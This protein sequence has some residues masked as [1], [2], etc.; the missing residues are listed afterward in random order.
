MA[1]GLVLLSFLLLAWAYS[2]VM[3]PFENLDEIEHFSAIRF[4]AET[5]SLPV[6]DQALQQE[7]H[8]RQEAS[9][10]PLYYVLMGGLTRL[11]KLPTKDTNSYLVTNPFVAC[12]PADIPY[13]RHTLYH[14]PA[15]EAFSL[16]G[17]GVLPWEGALGTLH[18]LRALAP[19]LQLVTILAVYAVARVILPQHPWVAVLAAGVTAFNPQFLLVSSGVNNDNLVTPLAV[20]GVLLA[21]L[22]YQR[23][24][25]LGLSGA[26]GVIVGVA[27]LS[28]LSGFLPLVLMGLVLLV[29]GWR[30][31]E[32]RRAIGH[33]VLTAGVVAFVSGWWFW[34]NWRL[35]GDLTALEPML[36]LVG[37]RESPIFPLL[38]SD[39]MFRSFWGQIACAFYSD[40]FYLFFVLLTGAG[41]AGLAIAIFRSWRKGWREREGWIGL[42]WLA[43][44]L[45]IVVLMWACWDLLTP[46]PGGRLLFP[47]IVSTSILLAF[48]LLWLWPEV[49]RGRVAAAL[50]VLLAVAALATLVWE[51]H[52]LFALPQTFTAGARPEIPHPLDA[53]FGTSAPGDP[54]QTA[55]HIKLLGY[56]AEIMGEPSRLDL[57]L[58]WE[59]P[60]PTTRDY[61]LAVQLISPVPGDDNLRFNYNTWPGRGN[62]PTSAWPPGRVIADRYLFRLPDSD[63]ATQA[64]QLLVALYDTASGERLPVR[65]NE[66]N[67]GQGLVLTTL[68]VPGARPTCPGEAALAEPV[69]FGARPDQRMFALSGVLVQP[70]P[71]PAPSGVRVSLCWNALTPALVDYTVFVHLYDESGELLAT[72]DGPPMG[73]AFPTRLWQPGDAVHDV[74]MIPVADADL[75]AAGD[76]SVDVG[77]YNL[78][79]GERLQAV[80]A[81]EH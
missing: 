12:G 42:L 3:P 52:P 37:R 49:W 38:E 36:N 16:E 11:L 77:L 28:K 35:Y 75:A 48:G 54:A 57:T 67:V 61:A 15:R 44:W 32:W 81:S 19:V 18:F 47:A 66:Q 23:G 63:A 40:R 74:H 22:T 78:H 59:A 55:P 58:Y 7:Y 17:P 69:Y 4:F 73:G 13:N 30:S 65:L 79:S 46:A 26:F 21:L 33:G 14:N 60:A 45:G 2:L 53:V 9:Q 50:V 24:P 31:G 8:Y 62:Y 20:L 25:S 1:L 27:G 10:P 41:L 70:N 5:G 56:D 72:G 43:L 34:R 51:L 29:Y 76:F 71:G 68:R 64:W 39:L 6:H 80:G